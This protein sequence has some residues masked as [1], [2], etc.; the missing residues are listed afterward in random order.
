[1]LLKPCG[2]CSVE[3][4]HRAKTCPHCGIKKPFMPKSQRA[5]NDVANGLMGLGCALIILVPLVIFLI[6]LVA[7]SF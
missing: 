6:S 2:E 1:M 5:V 4:S 7:S 3:I